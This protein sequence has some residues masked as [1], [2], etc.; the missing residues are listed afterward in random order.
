MFGVFC[1]RNC[2]YL[3]HQILEHLKK[4]QTLS[5][6]LSSDAPS[7]LDSRRFR[8]TGLR[9]N[10]LST[11][12]EGKHQPTQTKRATLAWTAEGGCPYAL[13]LPTGS[14]PE[15]ACRLAQPG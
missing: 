13:L 1:R 9:Q 11:Q 3:Q 6:G 15:M 2:F 7:G 10:K 5:A 4:S 8:S 14:R 12:I